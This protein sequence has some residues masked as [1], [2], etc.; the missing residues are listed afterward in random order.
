[1]GRSAETGGAGRQS[2]HSRA[3]EALASWFALANLAWLRASS[4]GMTVDA[5]DACPSPRASKAYRPRYFDDASG[6]YSACYQHQNVSLKVLACSTIWKSVRGSLCAKP[7]GW[8]AAE[9]CLWYTLL[10]A[11]GVPAPASFL[12]AQQLLLDNL[13][14]ENELLRGRRDLKGSSERIV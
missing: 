14:D 1:M 3:S 6:F 12:C 5:I 13:A 8:P 7:C 9:P 10:P 11:C 4:P 2:V